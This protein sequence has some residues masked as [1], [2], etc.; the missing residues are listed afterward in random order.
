MSRAR[1]R[2][3]FSLIELIIVVVIIGII[4]AIAIPKMSRGARNAGA[5][6][7]KM[8][9]AVLRNAVELYATEHDGKFPDADIANQL[10]QYSNFTGTVTSPTKITGTSVVYGPYLKD[11]P[12][13]PVGTTKGDKTFVI[14]NLIADVPPSDSAAGWWFNT[15]NTTVRANLPDT[16]VDDDTAMYNTY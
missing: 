3:G 11:I 14:A 10:T 1:R 6:T 16:D 13:M 9:L 15:A 4:S 2:T 5:N 8:D 12:P 7:L